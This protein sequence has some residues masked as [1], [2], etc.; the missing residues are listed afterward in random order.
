VLIGCCGVLLLS[1]ILAALIQPE[2]YHA[3]FESEGA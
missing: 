2:R 1:M 3:E